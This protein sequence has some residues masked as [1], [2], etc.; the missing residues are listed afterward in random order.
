MLF[1]PFILL[2]AYLVFIVPAELNAQTGKPYESRKVERP[3]SAA[4]QFP[5]PVTFTDITDRSGIS[6]KHN[7]SMTPTKYLLET[8][9][10]GVGLLDFDGD[11]RL[12]I[13]FT[14]GALIEPGM[15]KGKM[16]DKSD[17]RYWNRLY[18]Q[19]PDGT[20]EDVTQQAG[21]K[22]TGYSFGVAVGDYDRDGNS[23]LFVTNYGGAILY[24]NNGNG[25]FSD[26]T[27]RSGI[28][29][30]GWAASA[31]FFDYDRDGRLD[32]FVTRYI[33]WDFEKGSLVCG[34]SRPGYRSYCHP[35]NFEGLSSVLFHQKPDG[36]FENV[37][38][39]AGITKTKGKALGVA[40]ADL[41]DD[42]WTDIFVANDNTAQQLFRNLGNGRFEDVA[43]T[44]GVAFDDKGKAFAGMGIDIGDYDT[45]DK[46]DIIATAFSGETYPLYRNAGELLFDYTTQTSGVAQNTNLGT[47]WGVKFADVDNDGKRDLFFVQGH[48]SDI[49]EKST[50]FLKYKQPTLLLRNTG[51]GF[52]NISFAAGSFFNVG[53]SARGMAAGDLDNDGDTDFV[54]AQTDGSPVILRNNGTKN[55]WIGVDLRGPKGSAGGENARVTV[56][57]RDGSKQVFDV[58]NAGSY[59]AASDHRVIVG[60]GKSAAKQIQI[61]WPSGTVQS[62]ENPAMEIY[63]S[64]REK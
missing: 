42:G 1:R 62:I 60:F 28:D 16:P 20:F 2:L 64:I 39:H 9:G 57:G 26:V 54:I 5:S 13:F 35:D 33:S 24:R 56:T 8:M 14:N 48:V 40:F 50:D 4:P 37:S 44:A 36:T 47:G 7:A 34:D 51:K 18:R 31:G 32:L 38:E 15:K 22:G 30:E 19:K 46:Q 43:L 45:D 21:V 41:D 11:G 49:I 58:S 61:R 53:L 12:D 59:L 52:Q 29:I 17:R 27:E 3:A 10:G 25:T 23:D 55:R 63:H 6:F